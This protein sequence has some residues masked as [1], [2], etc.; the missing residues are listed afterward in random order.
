MLVFVLYYAI[1]VAATSMCGTRVPPQDGHYRFS[2]LGAGQYYLRFES[3]TTSTSTTTTR[4]M[5]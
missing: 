4:P 1:A 5:S 2:Q 3:A